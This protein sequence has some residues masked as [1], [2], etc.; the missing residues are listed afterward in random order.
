MVET[1]DH[2]KAIP[3]VL[4]NVD[5]PQGLAVIQRRAH[6]IA[7]QLLQL[8]FSSWLWQTDTTDMGVQIEVR[9]QFPNYR[10]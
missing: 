1:I 2:R 6:E 3:V 8:C 4:Y 7:D 5:L 10:S 9:I